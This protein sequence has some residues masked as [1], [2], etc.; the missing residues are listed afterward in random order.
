MLRLI[1]DHR[2]LANVTGIYSVKRIHE[3]G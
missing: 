2:D 1:G 3:S